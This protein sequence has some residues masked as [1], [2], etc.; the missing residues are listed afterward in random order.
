[1]YSK[2]GQQNSFIVRKVSMID[3]LRNLPVGKPV[4]FSCREVGYLNTA[5]SAANRLESKGEGEWRIEPH[6]N[7]AHYTVT[8]LSKPSK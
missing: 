1:M 5:Y 7:G 3:T 8:R 6:D 2:N 4:E